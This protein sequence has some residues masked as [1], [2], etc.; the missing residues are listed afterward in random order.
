MSRVTNSMCKITKGCNKCNCVKGN[1]TLVL[2]VHVHGV[3]RTNFLQANEKCSY[4]SNVA[5]VRKYEVHFSARV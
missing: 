2:L 4:L 1:C 5:G 3:Y